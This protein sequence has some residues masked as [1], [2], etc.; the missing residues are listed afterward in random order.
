MLFACWSVKGGSGTTT[1]AAALAVLLADSSPHGALLIDAAGDLPAVLGLPEP[2]GPGLADW[3][4]ADRVSPDALGRLLVEPR[5]GLQLLPWG[6][7][8]T[9]PE[10]A[11]DR[12]LNVLS[13]DRRTVVVD[14][15]STL[16]AMSLAMAS[17]ASVSLLVLR[18]CFLALRRAL[19]APIRPSGVVLVA[20]P[21]RELK[22]ADI[23]E[24]LGVPVRVEIPWAESI[25]RAVDCGLLEVRLPRMLTRPLRAAA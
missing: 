20:E 14:C 10:P 13:G 5:P 8:S 15:G 7:G 16:S 23:D 25:A 21:G 11:I 18:P 24:A 17:A 1:V 9:P 22:A 2:E 12:L 6:T 19:V 3:L 4:A